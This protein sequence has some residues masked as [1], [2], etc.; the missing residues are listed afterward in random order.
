MTNTHTVLAIVDMNAQ[1]SLLSLKVLRGL[2]AALCTADVTD[3]ALLLL[4]APETP[5]ASGDLAGFGAAYYAAASGNLSSMQFESIICQAI[6]Q[7][8]PMW[9]VTA[10]GGTLNE[11]LIRA[12]G[13]CGLAHLSNV[14]RILPPTGG[15]PSALN[16]PSTPEPTSKRCCCRRAAPLLFP[17]MPL[18]ICLTHTPEPAPLQNSCLPSRSPGRTSRP[19]P[20]P[21]LVAHP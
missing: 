3:I 7:L 15:R 20:Q 4:T 16:A 12:A 13:I 8:Q 10:G 17:H 21:H 6:E 19:Q 9:I 5:L 11:G 14:I 2:A 18:R 1:D